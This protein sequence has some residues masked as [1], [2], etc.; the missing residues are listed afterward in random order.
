M[1][2]MQGQRLDDVYGT[3]TERPEC[4]DAEQEE[5]ES[6]D[7]VVKHVYHSP[8]DRVNRSNDEQGRTDVAC[9]GFAEEQSDDDDTTSPVE[10]SFELSYA[11]VSDGALRREG[12]VEMSQDQSASRALD[13]EEAAER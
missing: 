5:K 7:C 13:N 10:D 4:K 12:R 1:D 8:D 2:G 11:D 3:N 6:A 9:D